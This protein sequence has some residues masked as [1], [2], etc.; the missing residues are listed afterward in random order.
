MT[1]RAWV[2]AAVRPS[3]ISLT[4]PRHAPTSG[5]MPCTS[6]TASARMRAYCPNS[7]TTSLLPATFLPAP[8]LLQRLGDFRRH[9]ILIVLRQH[10]ARGEYT[11]VAPSPFSDHALSFAKEIRN[12]AT[13]GHRYAV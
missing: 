1:S 12:D 11:V 13:V 4:S 9:I 5:S 3:A 6:A 8:R 7:G 10:L 2:S